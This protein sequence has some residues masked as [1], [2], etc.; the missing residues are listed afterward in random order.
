MP[1]GPAPAQNP[2]PRVPQPLGAGPKIQ[3]SHHPMIQKN[4]DNGSERIPFQQPGHERPVGRQAP[5]FRQPAPRGL[6]PAGGGPLVG[7]DFTAGAAPDQGPPPMI[8]V[9]MDGR[10]VIHQTAHSRQQQQARQNGGT[11]PGINPRLAQRGAQGRPQ[12]AP[13]YA[14]PAPVAPPQIVLTIPLEHAQVCRALLD[15]EHARV[16]ARIQAGDSHPELAQRIEQV[17][18]TAQALDA[19]LAAATSTPAPDAIAEGTG[20]V[21]LAAEP[22]PADDVQPE[23]P[24]VIQARP[25]QPPRRMPTVIS[26]MG[27]TTVLRHASRPTRNGFADV[28]ATKMSSPPKVTAAAP[29]V[30]APSLAPNTATVSL[31][32]AALPPVPAAVTV[33]PPASTETVVSAD[34]PAVVTPD[35]PPIQ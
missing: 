1:N 28:V 12:A 10:N 31:P 16:E 29:I 6:Q 23:A 14:A 22:E 8:A 34:A 32:A 9:R 17:I 2:R 15:D 24:P 3:I 35:A 5:Q 7:Q 33:A 30:A 20:P 11:I 25:T 4:M 13:Q 21:E 27:T 26:N 18:A 19:Y